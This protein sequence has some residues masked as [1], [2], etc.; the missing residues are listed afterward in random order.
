M[1]GRRAF[2]VGVLAGLGVAAAAGT[3]AQPVREGLRIGFLSP[4]A[5]KSGAPNLDALRQGLQE[6]GYEEGRNLTIE[7]RWADGVWPSRPL[8]S[9][10]RIG[11]SS[12][13]PTDRGPVASTPLPCS[14][15]GRSSFFASHVVPG[16][17]L[18]GADPPR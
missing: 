1:T 9:C 14:A 7:A 17:R 2:I 15:R 5:A 13:P 6:L 4:G 12:E 18:A 16:V 11:S 10:G 3:D 8:S